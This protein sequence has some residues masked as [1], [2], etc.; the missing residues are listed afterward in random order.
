MTDSNS[1]AL[2]ESLARA[3]KF[4]VDSK[5]LNGVAAAKVAGCSNSRMGEILRGKV[6][7]ISADALADVLGK[8]GYRV[9]SV[10]GSNDGHEISFKEVV[11]E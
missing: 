4:H 8:F 11:G 6:G 7:K 5:G 9:S 2:R 3:I 10:I 1:T